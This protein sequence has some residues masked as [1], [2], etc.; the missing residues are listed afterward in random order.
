MA[1]GIQECLDRFY[2]KHGP[3]CADCDHWKHLNAWVG[4]CDQLALSNVSLCQSS[5]TVMRRVIR[6]TISSAATSRDHIC[7]AF[8]DHFPWETLPLAYLE[9]IGARL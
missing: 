7:R 4:E 8:V 3:C 6:S 1:A 9:R 2:W 5:A